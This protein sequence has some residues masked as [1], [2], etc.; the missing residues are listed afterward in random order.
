MYGAAPRD[1]MGLMSAG[2]GRAGGLRELTRFRAAG[3]RSRRQ[4]DTFGDEWR[5]L[6]HADQPA[7]LVGH[8]GKRSH[9]ERH[10]AEDM[11]DETGF[12]CEPPLLAGTVAGPGGALALHYGLNG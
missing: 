8:C 9:D 4:L 2:P 10:D 11:K 7:A 5:E 1:A 6:V 12:H 3:N